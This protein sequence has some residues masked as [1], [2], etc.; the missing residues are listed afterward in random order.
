[1][2]GQR[3]ARSHEKATG[4]PPN[5]TAP[6]LPSIDAFDKNQLEYRIS[7]LSTAHHLIHFC[8]E[9]MQH[10]WALEVH[11]LS[12]I[13]DH[14]KP[15]FA[16]LFITRQHPSSAHKLCLSSLVADFGYVNLT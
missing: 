8:R 3:P 15:R 4:L 11:K 5:G 12:A 14:H 13:P 2:A 16:R 6:D 1:M 9:K 10:L 7:D